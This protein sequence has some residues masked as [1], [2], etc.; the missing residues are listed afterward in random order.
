MVL[1][2]D[3]RVGRPRCRSS[4]SVVVGTLGGALAV[5]GLQCLGIAAATSGASNQSF[6][7][8]RQGS[9][10]LRRAADVAR[11][12]TPDPFAGRENDCELEDRSP[13]G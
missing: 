13:S 4:L 7:R 6:E 3:S 1:G 9:V 8:T 12:S 11:R 2:W 5:I 10:R